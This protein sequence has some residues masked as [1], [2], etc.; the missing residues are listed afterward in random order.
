MR[1]SFHAGLFP[2]VDF[3]RLLYIW[4]RVEF[5]R[6]VKAAAWSQFPLNSFTKLGVVPM[7]TF[8]LIALDGLPDMWL[9]R[10]Q[11]RAMKPEKVLMQGGVAVFLSKPDGVQRFVKAP[12]ALINL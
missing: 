9:T 6:G 4:F 8:H 12:E 3:D 5:P 1:G 10:D 11:Y 7:E 2:V